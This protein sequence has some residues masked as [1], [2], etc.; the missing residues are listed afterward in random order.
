MFSVGWKVNSF[1]ISIFTF[2][3]TCA[4]DFS[5][6]SVRSFSIIWKNLWNFGKDLGDFGKDFFDFG[7]DLLDFSKDLKDF[8]KN[9]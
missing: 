7:K 5:S 1:I 4:T 8:G 6:V 2:L 9:L 3:V